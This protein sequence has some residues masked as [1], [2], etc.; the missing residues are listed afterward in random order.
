MEYLNIT[1]GVYILLHYFT[2]NPIRNTQARSS[3]HREQGRSSFDG[4]GWRRKFE[5]T[6]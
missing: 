3:G 4:V 1:F 2:K 5:R 6:P